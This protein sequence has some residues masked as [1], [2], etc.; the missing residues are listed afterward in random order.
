MVRVERL[1]SLFS[2]SGDIENVRALVAQSLRE[3]GD[4][5]ALSL[6]CV[7]E[8][9][10]TVSRGLGG[11]ASWATAWRRRWVRLGDALGR[12]Q[13][14]Y[15]ALPASLRPGPA[16]RNRR[17]YH[18]VAQLGA[19]TCPLGPSAASLGQ[20]LGTRLQRA[21]LALGTVFYVPK[22]RSTSPVQ[23]R[24]GDSG[25]PGQASRCP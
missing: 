25:R 19:S 1:Y 11:A 4:N 3:I 17:L 16:R 18:S 5:G 10:H 7:S 9:E 8:T 23:E 2:C 14:P 15:A 6:G 22:T 21:H 20:I 13:A 24:R 12:R